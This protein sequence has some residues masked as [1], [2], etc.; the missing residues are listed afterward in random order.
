MKRRIRIAVI[1]LSATVIAII[2]L[3]IGLPVKLRFADAVLNY[4]AA[5]ILALLLPFAAGSLGALA[6]PRSRWLIFFAVW[7]A[8]AVPCSIFSLLTYWE[9]R[10]IKERG[11]DLSYQLLDTVPGDDSVFRLY[12]TNCGATCS[13]GLDLRSEFDG[14]FGIRIVRSIWSAYKTDNDA[15]LMQIRPGLLQV[16]EAGGT[17]HEVQF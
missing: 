3:N 14:P 13:W 15:R 6:Q 16:M 4:W 10:D 7:F 17:T 9:A 1:V 5:L 11:A 2:G 8:F 12:L